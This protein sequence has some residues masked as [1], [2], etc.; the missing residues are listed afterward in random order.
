LS[1][2]P[3][4]QRG[5]IEPP[6]LLLDTNVYLDLAD[7]RLLAV[8]KRLDAI[9]A[10]RDPPLFWA[11]EL[12]FDELVCHITEDE[13]ADFP[14]YRAAL[15]W[16]ERLCK[17]LGMAEPLKWVIR[18]GVFAEVLPDDRKQ[19]EA[20]RDARR[21]ILGA[22]RYDQLSPE[23]RE[24]IEVMRADY[25]NRINR[26]VEG[27][28]KVQAVV[29]AELGIDDPAK[30]PRPHQVP[31][32]YTNEVARLLFAISRKH[33][34]K[35]ISTWGPLRD[36]DDQKRAQREM[37]AFEVALMLKARNPAGYD[38]AGQRSDY[39]DYWLLAY[40]AAGYRLVTRDRPLRNLVRY[41]GCPDGR[42]MT[43]AEGIEEA[44]DWIERRRTEQAGRAG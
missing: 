13:A 39:N 8:E 29:R 34:A 14:L 37:I 41:G 40:L 27:R 24:L 33:A 11:C 28:T 15:W 20:L 3:N 21:E 32:G 31:P 16:M 5:D 30:R 22:E 6:R 1:A 7:R 12:T 25:T 38:H 36:D 44:E 17:G 2:E 9:A 19:A 10:H 43:L 26:W 23:L 42:L 35:G 4:A 18:R